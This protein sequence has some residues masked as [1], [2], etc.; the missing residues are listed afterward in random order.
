MPRKLAY[1]PGN[2]SGSGGLPQTP[3]L[4]QVCGEPFTGLRRER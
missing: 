4:C 2:G 3:K 1:R